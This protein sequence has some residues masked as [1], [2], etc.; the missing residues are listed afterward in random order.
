MVS[1][2]DEVEEKEMDNDEVG[3]EEELGL[4]CGSQ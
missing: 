1:D 4:R 2:D 3:K